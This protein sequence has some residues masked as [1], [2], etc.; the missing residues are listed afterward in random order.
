M[1]PT[2]IN[3][4]KLAS[5][6][7]D[8]IM[9]IQINQNRFCNLVENP[10][11]NLDI[12]EK[13]KS[14]FSNL[15]FIKVIPMMLLAIAAAAVFPSAAHAIPDVVKPKLTVTA[16]SAATSSVTGT[17][18]GAFILAGVATDNIGVD[19][20]LVSLNGG[21]PA[22]ATLT[23]AGAVTTSYSFTLNPLGGINTVTTQVFDLAGNFS[24][25]VTRKFTYVVK[26][27]LTVNT[28][29]PGA[30]TGKLAG[31]VYQVGKSYTL[32]A[33]PTGPGTTNIFN[34]WAGVGLTTP[35]TAVPKLTFVFT[36]AMA[37]NPVFSAAFI[38]NRFTLGVIGSYN[39]LLTASVLPASNE[40]VG[41]ITL[42]L[43]PSGSFTGSLKISGLTLP[44]TGKFDNMGNA[45][46]GA[47]RTST[48]NINR[49]GLP[50]LVLSAV[51]LD[52]PPAM[53]HQINGSLGQLNRGALLPLSSLVA[54]RAAFSKTTVVPSQ[55]T[56]NKG[57]YT[58]V[59]PAQAQSNGL[60]T[61]DFPQGD[62]IGS[63]TVTPA[64]L[65]TLS[66]KLADGTAV[67]ASAP[68]SA[69]LTSPLF[70]QL[71]I[72]KAGS[73]GGLIALNDALPNSDLTGSGFLWFKPYAGGVNYPYGWPEGVNTTLAGAKYVAVPGTCV[74]PGLALAPPTA[75]NA[76]LEFQMGGLTLDVTKALNISPR[77]VV[78]RLNKPA[79]R[80]YS[81]T[82]TAATGKFAGMFT[83]T[84][85]THPAFS[86]VVY[87]KGNSHGGY[88]Y[89][90][91]SKPKVINAGL[92][93]L[94][95]LV[96]L[97]GAQGPAPVNLGMAG[98]FVILS[99]TGITD[100]PSSAITGNIGTSPIT[101][102]AIGVTCAEVTGQIYTVDAAGPA[103]RTQDANL[104][105]LSVADME[106]AYSDAA[107][108]SSPD[109]TE[110]GAG[111]ISG[112]EL[113]PGLYKWSSSVGMASDVTLEGGA[114]DVWIF[115]V[116]GNLSAGSGA[117]ITLT[118]GAQA[119]N[120]FWQVAGTTTLNT[121]AKFKGVILCQSLIAMN[122]GAKLEGRALAQTAVT[123]QQNVIT[124]P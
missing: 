102:A 79:D 31:A 64:G 85:K 18:G 76:F 116:A 20:V 109:F 52:L 44:L 86:G 16:P 95:G 13:R 118:G 42:K 108:R 39:G 121:G 73:F 101:G 59:I 92:S 65:V 37:L 38:I 106:L 56:M 61:Q 112:M 8:N 7:A 35:A 104:L 84:D 90:V 103:C 62:G 100:V 34:G 94:S 87:Q 1:K 80:S 45:V 40:S 48:V 68:L 110:L 43:T 23:T 12:I 117:G 82:L 114:D 46:F 124:Q 22:L 98:S 71:Y 25:L 15:G 105:L 70:A 51:I 122:T 69:E 49:I 50:S 57:Y 14:K 115:Q 30:V 4:S 120:V 83:H 24:I 11:H 81:L 123:L 99:K 63:I 111:T 97:R 29:G 60:T 3:C 32:T 55:Y 66:G 54:E 5:L 58:V 93:N 77:N 41:F 53:S 91:T 9:H 78:T 6:E 21:V 33:V 113:P 89:F 88:G 19:H 28:T 119:K 17:P 67:T 36:D 75:H 2:M 47:A 10:F 107:G 96:T 74:L 72:R 26:V 27:A